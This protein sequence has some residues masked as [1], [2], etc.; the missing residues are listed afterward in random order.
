M[1]KKQI[2]L[3]DELASWLDGPEGEAVNLSRLCRRAVIEERRRLR[4]GRAT[5]DRIPA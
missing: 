2:Y 3:P 1:A 5:G 4:E